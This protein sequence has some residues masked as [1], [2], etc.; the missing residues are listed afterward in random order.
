MKHHLLLCLFTLLTCLP[1]FSRTVTVEDV[2]AAAGISENGTNIYWGTTTESITPSG[3]V[4]IEFR[5]ILM[6][7]QQKIVV[8]VDEEPSKGWE[9]NS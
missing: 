2:V 6:S 7:N 8:F 9:H 3:Y 4:P 1:V 5:N